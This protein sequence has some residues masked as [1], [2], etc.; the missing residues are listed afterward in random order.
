MSRQ[1]IVVLGMHRSGTS[2]VARSLEVLGYRAGGKLLAPARDNPK[3]FF[4]QQSVV[5]LN[6]LLLFACGSPWW[7]AKTIHAEKARAIGRLLAPIGRRIISRSLKRTDLLYLKDPRL[8]KLI[9]FWE[10][11]FVLLDLDIHWLIVSRDIEG[12]I[13]S[14]SRRSKRTERETLEK[15]WARYAATH[16][17]LMEDPS[18][19]TYVVPITDFLQDP[20]SS[21]GNLA[22]FSGT[23]VDQQSLKTYLG[24]FLDRDLFTNVTQNSRRSNGEGPENQKAI[25]TS[26]STSGAFMT[27]L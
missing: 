14:L 26:D 21:L 22:H 4:E 27:K 17:L 8:T 20:V 12:V 16:Q 7:S 1:L 10:P 6:E 11:I 25:S 23:S 18:R 2:L 3:G 5:L 13:D 19:R 15:L 9:W 24:D